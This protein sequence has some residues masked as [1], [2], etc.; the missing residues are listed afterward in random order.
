MCAADR[1][2]SY[3]RNWACPPTC[4]SLDHFRALFT[5]FDACIVFQTVATLEDDFDIETM[6][7]AESLHK[8]RTLNMC[9][10]LS[11][12]GFGKDT[13]VLGAGTC[14]LCSPCAFPDPCRH[15][16]QRIVSM[17]AAGLVVTETCEAACIPYY[18]G[19]HTIAYSGCL[20]VR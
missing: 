1:C 3:G 12:Q 16:A 17:E 19:L 14:T 4:G 10:T 6:T 18:H 5:S 20:L 15:P 7:R 8:Q 11:S 2:R 13:I 9:R